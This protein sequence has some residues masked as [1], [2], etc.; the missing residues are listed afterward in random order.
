MTKEQQE[1]QPDPEMIGRPGAVKT[2]SDYEWLRQM[3][4]ASTDGDDDAF[5]QR[6]DEWPTD[7]QRLED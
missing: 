3:L 2:S 1:K 6:Q 4:T 7:Q 5:W